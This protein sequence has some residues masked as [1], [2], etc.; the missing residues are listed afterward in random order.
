[1]IEAA[2]TAM[3]R[4]KKKANKKQVYW[5]NEDIAEARAKCIQDRRKWTRAKSKKRRMNNR[6]RGNDADEGYLKPTGEGR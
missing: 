5:W 3:K 4:T 2:D 6:E 1:M